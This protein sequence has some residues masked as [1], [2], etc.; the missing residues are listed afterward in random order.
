MTIDVILSLFLY[1]ANLPCS[2]GDKTIILQTNT[3]MKIFVPLEGDS[4]YPNLQSI[5]KSGM[6]DSLLYL[7]N[8]EVDEH[9]YANY[10]QNL[11]EKIVSSFDW[12]HI[13][14]IY[15]II[16]DRKNKQ[17]SYILQL[18]PLYDNSKESAIIEE[19]LKESIESNRNAILEKVPPS[20]RFYYFVNYII[21]H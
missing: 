5:D 13:R 14:I 12:F 11:I 9:F 18:P 19:V 16:I 7:H 3:D 4:M 1:A 10:K 8:R 15:W 20:G 17:I 2:E 21:F 6:S